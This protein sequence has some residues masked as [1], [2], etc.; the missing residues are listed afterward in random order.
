MSNKQGYDLDRKRTWKSV[1]I[2][3]TLETTCSNV[4]A[5]T[6][7]LLKIADILLIVIS[8]LHFFLRTSKF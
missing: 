1:I 7:I 2:V 5:T 4:S 8:A 6:K 3:S